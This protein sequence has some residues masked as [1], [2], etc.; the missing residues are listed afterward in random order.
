M[1]AGKFFAIAESKFGLG[2]P[3]P[4]LNFTFYIF[5]LI[6]VF[7]LLT[8]ILLFQNKKAVWPAFILGA[9]VLAL[10]TVYYLFTKTLVDL[11]I[12]SNAFRMMKIPA[13]ISLILAVALILNAESP[14]GWLKRTSWILLGPLFAFGGYIMI[15]K[16]VWNQTFSNTNKV[17]TDYTVNALY[18]L[19][20]FAVND[21]AANAT[22]REKIIEVKGRPSEVE[23]LSDSTGN[24]R[25]SDSTGSYI[26]F[27]FEKEQFKSLQTIKAGDSVSAKGSCSGS[28]HSEILGTT[29]ISFKRSTLNKK[30]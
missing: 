29:S 12:G 27:S 17:K 20:E 4:Q 14:I 22:Y 19:R 25:F 8:C 2:N 11:G 16:F 3:V 1:A 26:I 7:V 28:I 9:L 6:P 10:V 5:W 15:Q 21:S 23:V 18:L 30:Q 13:W 24:I